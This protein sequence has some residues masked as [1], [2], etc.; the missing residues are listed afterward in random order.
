M[1][2]AVTNRQEMGRKARGRIRRTA[3]SN[4]PKANT[5]F[6]VERA[7]MIISET[8]KKRKRRTGIAVKSAAAERVR[9]E[10]ERPK[11]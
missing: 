1:I 10:R 9:V 6:S 3:P 7:K 8:V 4:P 2:K 5:F 11:V